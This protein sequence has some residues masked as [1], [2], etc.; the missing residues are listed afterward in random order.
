LRYKPKA[1]E[2][3]APL[4]SRLS[5]F[6]QFANDLISGEPGVVQ[7]VVEILASEGGSKRIFELLQQPME[8]LQYERLAVIFNQ[9]L[10]PFLKTITHVNVLSSI[11]LSPRVLSIYNFLYFD[12]VQPVRVFEAAIR[13]LS[14]TQAATPPNRSDAAQHNIDGFKAIALAIS[15]MMEVCVPA[16]TNK[17]L[18]LIVGNLSTVLDDSPSD[19]FHFA[20]AAARKSL[21]LA[22]QRLGLGQQLDEIL[23]RRPRIAEAQAT[24]ELARDMPGALSLEGPRHD[25]DHEDIRS[26]SILPTLQEIQSARNEYLPFADPETWHIK[27]LG[28]LVDRHF[29]LLREDTVGQLRDAAKFELERLQNPYDPHTNDRK[30]IGA[31]IFVYHNVAVQDRAFTK[32]SGPEF[33][34]GF[35][36]PQNLVHKS[37]AARHEWWRNS[38]RFEYEALICLLSTAGLV[39]FLTVSREPLYKGKQEHEMHKWYQ[40]TGDEQERGY[41]IAKPINSGDILTL[42]EVL[43]RHEAQISLVEFP[44]IILPTFEP[45]LQALQSIRSSLDVPFADIPSPD[46]FSQE[47]NQTFHVDRPAYTKKAGFRFN[48]SPI[49]KAGQM[50][51]FDPHG[52]LDAVVQ[53][54]ESKSTLDHRQADAVIRSLSRAFAQIQ[55]PPGTGKSYTGNQLIKV[56][57]A[58]R[59]SADLGP[60]LCVCYTNHALDQQQERLLDEGVGNIVR[61]GGKSKSERLANVNLRELAKQL[62]LTKTER[63]DRW[64]HQ[65]KVENET[66][67]ICDILR[68]L[69]R[70]GSQEGVAAFLLDFYPEIHAQFFRDTDEDGFITVDHHRD[71]IFERWLRSAPAHLV[72]TRPLEVL[73]D[74]HINATSIGERWLLWGAWLAEMRDDL[75]DR[76]RDTLETYETEKKKLA[77]IRSEI[78]LRVLR[79]AN[80]IAVTTSG[81]ARNLEVLRRLNLKVLICEEAGEVLESHLL[82]ALLPSVEHAIL[83]GDHEQLRPQVHNYDLSVDSHSGV[84]YSLDVSLFERL[85]RPAELNTPRLELC[86]LDVQRR[87][88]PSISQLIRGIY[89]NLHDA[90]V[91]KD[92]P[93]VTGMRDRVY[94]MHHVHPEDESGVNQSTSRTNQY[95]VDMIAALARHLVRQGTYR[96]DEIAILT[97]YLGQLRQIKKALSQSFE[98]LLNDRD[99][100]DLEKQAESDL[101]DLEA[102]DGVTTLPARSINAA[103]GALS[104]ALRIATVDNFQ[105]EEASLILLSLVRSNANNTPGFLRTTNRIN[106]L[107]SRAKHGMYII[108][109]TNTMGHVKIWSDVI[110]IFRRDGHLG[111]DFVLCCPRHPDAE[112]M[113]RTPE[114]FVRLAPE[115]GCE[116]NCSK[117]LTCGHACVSK[118]HSDMLHDAVFCQKPCTRPKP[119]CTH[120]CPHPCGAPCDTDCMEIVQ[121][122]DVVLECGHHKTSLHCYQHQDPSR[123]RCAT[124]VDRFV[125]GCG[126][127]VAEP[128][129][130]DVESDNYM[131]KAKCGPTLACGHVCKQ[132]CHK[133]RPR[134]DSVVSKA[135]HGE[136]MQRCDRSYTL[137][138]HRCNKR[139]HG[140]EPCPLCVSPC[141]ARCSHGGCSRKCS[142]PCPP[143]AEAECASRCPHSQCQMPCAAPCDWIPC[144]RRCTKLLTCG[145][146][147]PSICGEA[148]PDAK[149]CQKCGPST[150]RE[151]QADLVMFEAYGDIDLDEDPCVFTACGHVFTLSSMDG[152]MDMPKHYHM[153]DLDAPI[154]IRFSSEPFSSNEMKACPTCRGSLRNIARYGR[155]VRRAMLDSSVKKLT[156]WARQTHQDLANKLLVQQDSLMRSR[157]E[158]KIFSQDIDLR[159]SP[160]KQI[161]HIRSLK[162]L[163]RYR[164]ILTLRQ[165]IF[166]FLEKVHEDEMPYQR[167][168]DL[169]ETSRRANM[170]REVSPF[171]VDNNV[172]QLGANLQ[173]SALFIRCDLILFA[174]VIALYNHASIAVQPSN[175]AVDFTDNMASCEVLIAAALRTTNIRQQV[176]GHIFWA[177]FATLTRSAFN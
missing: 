113:V 157:D 93:M 10:L 87:M 76:L 109:N 37:A 100:E 169:V 121:G 6:F 164:Q 117:L 95:E 149:F 104:Q 18:S 99:V 39:V 74:V 2:K 28:G 43:Y 85:A 36:Q 162:P 137:C 148:C 155:V 152:I 142:G 32:S 125:P 72:Q 111:E 144:S 71:A 65:K 77:T 114:D 92:Y 57:L 60:I 177:H 139:C 165:E 123:F 150:I 79:Q 34:L 90:S 106:V 132:P 135:D 159:G 89:P 4:R 25:N 75:E 124:I 14:T 48:L 3:G 31:R 51:S 119:N 56:L 16:Q 58:A 118:C 78:D 140:T 35:D 151:M 115:A 29:R 166:S 68:S 107:L 130:I 110:E 41:V 82:T 52:S 112:M 20:L 69:D 161:R 136:C 7:E 126:H 24:F 154:A 54:L 129:Y 131:C 153:N 134:K 158:E 163:S 97:P 27:G 12:G 173:A 66:K 70:L 171:V 133:C 26:I 45:T 53:E 47:L 141:D 11:L 61:I 172:F 73:R 38:K 103:R 105:G 86:T 91:V 13:Y 122:I 175:L 8:G 5:Q 101:E 170:D 1:G 9:Q 67:A 80:I 21:R 120:N 143:C 44:G 83:I 81:L 30:R 22:E 167:V 146:Q 42:T 50:M 64:S 145:C 62:D 88:H 98:I 102:L 84:Q 63:H 33:A 55:G 49:T 19:A 23:K 40:L 46:M 116:L 138:M 160:E 59:T 96:S 168:R 94:W 127:V 128:C 176:E 174:D 156:A 147:C 108:G 15:K 17:N